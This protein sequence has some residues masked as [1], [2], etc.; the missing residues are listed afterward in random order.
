[1]GTAGYSK[2]LQKNP[3]AFEG[4]GKVTEVLFFSIVC[5]LINVNLLEYGDKMLSKR[6]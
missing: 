3:S 6:P 4:Q 5:L 1:L 2:A